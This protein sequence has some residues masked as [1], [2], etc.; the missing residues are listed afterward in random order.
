VKIFYLALLL[1]SVITKAEVHHHFHI[2]NEE[3]LSKSVCLRKEPFEIQ[4]L[5][6]WLRVQDWSERIPQI[7]ING[8][9]FINESKVLLDSFN[10]LTTFFNIKNNPG[11]RRTFES[12]CKSILCAM[13]E[14][15]G[16][17]TGVQILHIYHRYGF[18]ASHMR[19]HSAIS[20]SWRKE[21]LDAVILALSDFPN[22]FFP[23]NQVYP[24]YH[25]RRDFESKVVASSAIR[26]FSLWNKESKLRRRSS[27]FHEIA[28]VVSR[29]GH[30]GI[31]KGYDRSQ[32]WLN[33]AHWE[34]KGR[35]YYI[36]TKK[37]ERYYPWEDFAES[38]S[39]YR[40]AGSFLKE[41]SPLRYE[42]IKAFLF[43]NKEYL[44][45]DSCAAI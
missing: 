38:V 34:K 23:M 28:H 32:E 5:E 20:A 19:Q 4:E 22:G 1:F 21:E 27:I 17:E 33:L 24:L 42:K 16:N 36:Q 9:N 43:Y 6:E 13:K 29:I 15:F 11:E 35:N 40:Y 7:N 2:G 45:E 26:V 12:G 39:A 3:T 14:I 41:R 8:I 30:R 37:E 31:E 18:N 25:Y 44:N 10:E